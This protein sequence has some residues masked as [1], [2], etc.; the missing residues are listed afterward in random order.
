MRSVFYEAQT[1]LFL[2]PFLIFISMNSCV[3]R[4][5]LSFLKGPYLGQ[6]PPGMTPEIFAPGVVSTERDEIN[7]VFSS[8][9]AEFSG[10][11]VFVFYEPSEGK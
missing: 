8:N 10:W 11:K 4:D 9:G 3:K 2:W 1:G 5:E 7:S 6:E